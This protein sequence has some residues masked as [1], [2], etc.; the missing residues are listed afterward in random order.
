[1]SGED[2]LR[3]GQGHDHELALLGDLVDGLE[4][5]LGPLEEAGDDA[6]G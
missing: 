6:P 3:A 1:M 5:L 4:K 2:P